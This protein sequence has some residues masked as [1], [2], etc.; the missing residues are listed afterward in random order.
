MQVK[1]E[2]GDAFLSLSKKKKRKE[3]KRK[4]KKRK[5]VEREGEAGRDRYT[6]F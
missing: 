3:K 6:N 1:R 2:L 5:K 4:E